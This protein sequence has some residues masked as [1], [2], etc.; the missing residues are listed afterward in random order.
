MGVARYCGASLVGSCLRHHAL[1]NEAT[2]WPTQQDQ[3]TVRSLSAVVAGR[4]SGAGTRLEGVSERLEPEA[5]GGH[6]NPQQ[7]AHQQRTCP[8]A[9]DVG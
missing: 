9:T 2:A 1:Y 3:R 7:G 6:E 4:A 5:A 8:R